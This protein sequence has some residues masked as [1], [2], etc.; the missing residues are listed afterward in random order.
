MNSA[1]GSL[2][3]Q[4]D[5]INAPYWYGE[6]LDAPYSSKGFGSQSQLM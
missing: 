6:N 2:I 4:I 1:T 3:A 5:Q